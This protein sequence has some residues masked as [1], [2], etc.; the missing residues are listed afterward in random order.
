MQSCGQVVE[1]TGF[2]VGSDQQRGMAG[3]WGHIERVRGLR[4]EDCDLEVDDVVTM[5]EAERQ[6]RWLCR[7]EVVCLG[8]TTAVYGAGLGSE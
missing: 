1:C 5:E 7:A 8:K 2:F 4:V 3:R 6:S